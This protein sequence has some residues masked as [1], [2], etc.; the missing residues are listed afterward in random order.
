MKEQ[1]ICYCLR[2]TEQEI[3]QAIREGAKT[4]KDTQKATQACTGNQCKQLNPSG[5][6]CSR[7]ILKIIKRETGTEPTGECCCN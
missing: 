5:K 4:L 2:V 1:L 6:C 3:V 7:D